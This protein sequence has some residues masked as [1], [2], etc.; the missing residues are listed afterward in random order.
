MALNPD[1]ETALALSRFGLGSGENGVSALT[2]NVRERL[3]AEI[4]AGAPQPRSDDLRDTPTLLAEAY[5]YQKEKAAA[6][7]AART[8]DT[9]AA[10]TGEA[11]DMSSAAMAK[12]GMP[13]EQMPEQM[14]AQ[15]RGA[16]TTTGPN[17]IRDAG[18]AEIRA[19]F[20]DTM[21]TPDIG[22]NERMVM[23]WTNHFAV[24]TKKSQPV[25]AISGAYER[26]AIRPHVFGRFHDLLLA[27]ETHPCMLLYLDN[28]QSVGPDSPA[29]N[30][31]KRGLNE[32]LARE[33]MELHT[34]GVGSGYTQ[35]DVTSFAKV[36][37]GWSVSR[38][39]KQG[40]PGTFQFNARAH[41]P[42]TQTIMG[43]RYAQDGL[44]QGQAVL[45]DLARH[46][47]TARHIATKLARHFVADDPPPALVEQL[48]R[49]FLDSDGDLAAVSTALIEA[50][51]AWTPRLTKIRSPLEYVTAA[52]RAT[53]ATLRPQAITQA[54]NAMGQPW[55]QPAGPNGFPD[56]V[57]AWASPEGLSTRMDFANSLA[58]AA[59][60][61]VDPRTFAASHLGPLLSVHT[62]QAI[63]RA[64]TQAQGLS[65]ALLSPEF[66]RR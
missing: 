10:M 60:K 17:P 49:T 65:L 12:S 58:G 64:E 27:V 22:F 59:D 7:K 35:A 52:L 26:E 61:S 42:G 3:K 25:A 2:G 47:A 62:A 38:S 33:I 55:W 50:P 21:I 44:A 32:N 66:M 53:G 28:A 19:R 46:P 41:E 23:F 1:F 54:L 5:D 39:E 63:A 40:P 56:T 8:N 14:T 37:T 45:A 48:S 9:P 29:R 43:K 24:S 36:I 31:G 20:N 57:A 13:P 34:L 11:T 51:E 16:K 4:K 18:L 30:N 15:K 6:R